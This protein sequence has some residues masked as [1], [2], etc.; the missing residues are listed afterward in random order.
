MNTNSNPWDSAENPQLPNETPRFWGQLTVESW[1]CVLEKGIGKKPF[2][3]AVHPVSSRRTAVR[4]TVTTLPEHK[5]QNPDVSREYIAEEWGK[6][7]PWN[8]ITLPSFRAV[9][10]EPRAPPASGSAW[11]WCPTPDVRLGHDRRNEGEHDDQ[12]GGRV[13]Q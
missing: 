3:P 2:D 4:V 7:K 6:S 11:S 10:L 8:Q 13:S 5:L 12:A 9:G 1:F